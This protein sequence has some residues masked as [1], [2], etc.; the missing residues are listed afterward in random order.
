MRNT[1][2]YDSWML[3]RATILSFACCTAFVL[4]GVM[5]ACSSAG[6]GESPPAS[7]G[8]D[9]STSTPDPSDAGS[10]P[11]VDGST[12]GGSA[13]DATADA[14]PDGGIAWTPVP[15]SCSTAA[16]G[17]VVQDLGHQ[18]EVIGVRRTTERVLADEKD[19]GWILWDAATGAEI[20]GAESGVVAGFSPSAFVVVGSNVE[21]RAVSDGH[22]LA[23]L[24]SGYAKYG[25][26]IDGS[27][28]W[29]ASAT[30]LK[31]WSTAGAETASRSGNYGSAVVFGAP[32]ELRVAK[33]A[34]GA[35][36]IE[37]VTPAGASTM[38]PAFGG[39]FH[40]WFTDG[41]HFLATVGTT[42][43]LVH[44]TT[45][46][47]V[48]ALPVGVGSQD[49]LV[50][51]N[52]F[53]WR[54]KGSTPGYPLDVF[55]LDGDGTP[56]FSRAFSVLT[57]MTASADEIG[58]LPFGKGEAT[59][60][61][62]DPVAGITWTVHPTSH[63]YL[64]SFG[65]SPDGSWAIGTRT[66]SLLVHG[67]AASPATERSLGCGKVLS[68]AGAPTGRVA[69]ATAST[70]VLVADLPSGALVAD[71]PFAS[72]EVQLSA[73]GAVLAEMA[74][75]QG[76]QYLTDRTLNLVALPSGTVSS[77]FPFSYDPAGSNRFGFEL[78]ANG[79]RFSTTFKSP[80]AAPYGREVID[81]ATG[82]VVIA[83]TGFKPL[84]RIS[85]NGQRIAMTDYEPAEMKTMSTRLYDGATLVGAVAGAAVGWL[86]DNRV[87]VQEYGFKPGAPGAGFAYL[88]SKIYDAAGVLVAS[89]AA[90]PD[91]GNTS[92][93]DSTAADIID[94]THV[95]A[96][97]DSRLFDAYTG[98]PVGPKMPAWD[99]GGG[100][101]TAAG[102]YLVGVFGRRL[103]RVT[104]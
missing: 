100:V 41:G 73:S 40:S 75:T 72:S 61:H 86:D 89:P 77:T 26:A 47:L 69:I 10:G 62:L 80:A 55:T 21:L 70:R 3:R 43:V 82:D 11:A 92:I 13:I 30:G 74:T 42:N 23:K 9:A 16:P 67:D 46:T 37:R 98:K 36:V 58:I 34:G 104:Y 78:S 20:A 65:A 84:P 7:G 101:A 76:S 33:G 50:G 56:V 91:L 81:V 83:D 99:N 63:A 32:A 64:S 103:G 39:T 68:I 2:C 88:A 66:G 51:Q 25:V 85:P 17:G 97:R 4:G 95:F 48:K 6:G 35:N 38:G 96:R 27:Y 90:L 93:V 102:P 12:D 79:E 54:F 28:A 45:G 18:K 19:G 44:D 71:I 8:G 5:L 57:S 53:V 29:G 94:A 52:A 49:K 59:I 14:M 15:L 22:V 24:P 60:L 1:R 31:V 87:L